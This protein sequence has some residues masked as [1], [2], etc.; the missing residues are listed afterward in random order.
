MER[1]ISP[2]RIAHWIISKLS[3]YHSMFSIVNDFNGEY[4]EI[5]L[6]DG[7][8]RAKL[9]YWRQ[10]MLALVYYFPLIIK[11][12]AGMLK[13]YIK[14][15]FRN[16]FK[17]KGYSFINISGLAIGMACFILIV[18]YIQY[19]LSYDRFHDNAGRI[20]KVVKR[21]STGEQSM[22]MPAPFAPALGNEFPEIEAATRFDEESN[23][24]VRIG[25]NTFIE[26]RLF[27]ADNQIFDV[28]T[29]P[30]LYGNPKTALV[31]P[32]SVVIDEETAYKYFGTENPIG[33]TR[34]FNNS[35]DVQIT[36]VMKNIPENSHFKTHF[37]ASVM[38][39][40]QLG[41]NLENWGNNFFH[42]YILLKE[43][44]DYRE[45]EDK[46][47]SFIRTNTRS[48]TTSY[49]LRPLTDIHLRS[50][51]TRWALAPVGD[52]KQVYI[53]TAT[54]FII[55]L[56]AC[57]NY[58]NLSTARGITRSREVS[59]RKV[60][61]AYRPQLAWQ[62][63]GES[64]F[65]TFAALLIA[66]ALVCLFIRPF[67]N[68]AE[69]D[70][71]IN[72]IEN[73][74]FLLVLLSAGLFAGIFSGSYPALYLSGF[75]PA[76]ILKGAFSRNT[77]G[78]FFRNMLIL[79]Q[80]TI[81]I[82]LISSAFVVSGQLDYIRNTKLG[83][84]RDHIVLMN[85]GDQE[86]REYGE[87]L[88][89]E[90][91]QNPGISA[92]AFSTL[93]PMQKSWWANSVDYEGREQGE[94]FQNTYFT[95][96]DYDFL[97]VYGFEFVSGRNFSRE[98]A[99]DTTGGAYIINETLARQLGWENPVGKRIR[100][101]HSNNIGIVV[102]VVKDFHHATMYNS[103]APVTFFLNFE[104]NIKNISIKIHPGN[105]PET[106]AALGK[107]WSKHTN[108]NPFEYRFA[109]DAYDSMYR[110]E[111][112][113]N[114][115]FTYFAL[116]A[117]F[118]SCLGLFGLASFTAEQCTKEIGIRKVFGASVPDI[119]R[120]LSWKFTKWVILANVIA[121]PIGYYTMTR[122]LQNFAF[123]IDPGIVI[124]VIAAFIAF[125][126]AFGTISFQTIKA[127]RANPVESLRNE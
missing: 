43:G 95:H 102:G 103:M 59:I 17:Y 67:A 24:T 70:I 6:T 80:F 82:I 63:L 126:I 90:L 113:L 33:K 51:D 71:T 42:S 104:Q 89:Y 73:R 49:I 120:L 13:N 77:K 76:A 115:L 10:A 98:F 97:D 4:E 86:V 64:M 52:I 48:E 69:R 79:V 7:K 94:D 18:L 111:I 125:L 44:V 23:Y 46:F 100:L 106:V 72:L 55:L 91:L 105:V 5:F 107:I 114:T 54:A 62:F 21:F 81:S 34:N 47:Q 9:W 96:V 45:L 116:L 39:Y 11:V 118:I 41:V 3:V 28:F 12:E 26:D 110:S 60:V 121:L 50:T 53:F 61:G 15:A 35:Y 56:I 31:N 30:F 22:L 14:I 93:L 20:Y 124:F 101:S 65:F 8:F 78:I 25:D 109:D 112:R 75:K 2:P 16:L 19:E 84:D 88:R 38:T 99:G 122:W 92:V 27:F 36:G 68:F 58:M 57:V 37:L 1:K 123:R 108:G 66:T 85:I 127:A 74:G 32:H 29:L 40:G 119:F 117:V 87:N 83:F